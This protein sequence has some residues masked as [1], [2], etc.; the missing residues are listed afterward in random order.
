MREPWQ[1]GQVDLAADIAAEVQTQFGDQTERWIR[2]QEQVRIHLLQH[3]VVLLEMRQVLAA[4]L[5]VHNQLQLLHVLLHVVVE[6]AA[7]RR[8]MTEILHAQVAEEIEEDLSVVDV[9]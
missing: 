8:E 1:G 4:V 7:G 9:R 6:L 3:D 2:I 5:V